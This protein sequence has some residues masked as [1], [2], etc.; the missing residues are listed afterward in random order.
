MTN[1]QISSKW[2]PEKSALP[3]LSKYKSLAN[4]IKRHLHFLPNDDSYN[5]NLKSLIV[6]SRGET[7]GVKSHITHKLQHGHM[8]KRNGLSIYFYTVLHSLTTC[9]YRVCVQ[10][11]R[12]IFPVQYAWLQLSTTALL[13]LLQVINSCSI[14]TLN[15]LCRWFV[16]VN[17]VTQ[18]R[19]YRLMT[20]HLTI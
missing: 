14:K 8:A 7:S 3:T 18:T 20:E 11:T 17:Y 12:I 9:A 1:S 4:T 15:K 19:L 5:L 2:Q 6:S 10:R 16:K 13:R